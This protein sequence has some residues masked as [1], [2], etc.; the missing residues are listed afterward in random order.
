MYKIDIM[1]KYFKSL[2]IRDLS[3]W[4]YNEYSKP[5]PAHVWQTAD[6]G[7][8]IMRANKILRGKKKYAEAQRVAFVK[9]CLY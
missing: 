4:I 3:T 7:L 5:L 1:T 6:Q 2:T 9:K 8:C